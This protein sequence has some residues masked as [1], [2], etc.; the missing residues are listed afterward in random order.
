VRR[1]VTP[2]A[3][4]RLP[5]GQDNRQSGAM[6]LVAHSDNILLANGRAW[7]C[8]LGRSG[9]VSARTKREGDGASPAGI[10]PVRRVLWRPDRLEQPRTSLLFQPI[11]PDDGWCDAPDDPAYNRPVRMPWPTSHEVMTRTDG[12]YD[13]VVILG[14][15]DSPP[16]PGMGSAIFLH[17]AS[18]DYQPTEG[19]IALARTD[20]LTLLAG[21]T[22]AS[23]VEISASPAPTE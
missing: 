1:T 18:P 11:A 4:R 16:I 9:V 14:H 22:Q 19:C 3:C 12:L 8:A 5:N 17:C 2:T 7:P 23:T 21:M 10:W 15:N 6:K 20:L 13:V